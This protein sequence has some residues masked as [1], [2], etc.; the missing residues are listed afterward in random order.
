MPRD[1]HGGCFQQLGEESKN[2]RIDWNAV[3]ELKLIADVHVHE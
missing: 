3:D 1:W 2:R